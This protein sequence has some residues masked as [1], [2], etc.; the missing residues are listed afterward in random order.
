MATIKDRIMLLE[1]AN[2]CAPMLALSVTGRPTPEQAEQITKAARTGRRLIVFCMPG[3]TAWMPS[4]G[5]P[6]WEEQEGGKYGNA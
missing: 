1:C 5:V 3:D 2:N 6:P 4:A